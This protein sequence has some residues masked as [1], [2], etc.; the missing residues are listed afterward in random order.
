MAT[1][2]YTLIDST[3]LSSA[4]NNVTFTSIPTD[5]TCKDFI[6]VMDGSTASGTR[7][8]IQFNGDTNS[9][10]SSVMM[11]DDAGAGYSTITAGTYIDPIPGFSVSGKFSAIW[12]VMDSNATDK[13][14][15]VLIRLNQ[16]DGGHVHAS[17]GRWASNNPVVSVKI[18]TSTGVNYSAGTT[19]YLYKI[20]G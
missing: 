7:P 3:T 2:T 16:H 14:K 9:S 6:I 12:Q 13:N 17:A 18:L 19:F 1:P 11:A 8:V 5:D 10:Y 20:A 15:S 4:A